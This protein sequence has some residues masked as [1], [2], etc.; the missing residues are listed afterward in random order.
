MN[1]LALEQ[2]V[3]SAL[4]ASAFTDITIYT[5]TD[6]EILTPESVNLIV[7]CDTAVQVAPGAYTATVS[8][9]LSAP[10]L[11]GADSYATFTGLTDRLRA[12]VTAD[13]MTAHWTSGVSPAFVGLWIENVAMSRSQ[14]E[15]VCV[16]TSTFGVGI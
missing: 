4:A 7:A 1:S 15:W 5:G 9:R 2:L 16:V 8:F 11:L 3:K 14:N 10:A 6:Y 13:Y 12:A